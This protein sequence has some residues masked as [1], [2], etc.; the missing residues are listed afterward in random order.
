MYSYR[1]NSIYFAIKG[2]TIFRLEKYNSAVTE[3][4]MSYIIPADGNLIVSVVT[5][6]QIEL[7]DHKKNK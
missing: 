4:Q 6:T 3:T 7:I 2:L 5:I 1:I